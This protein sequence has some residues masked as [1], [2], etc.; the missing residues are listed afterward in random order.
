MDSISKKE[1]D[2]VVISFSIFIVNIF[3]RV[4]FL[5]SC[6]FFLLIGLLTVKMIYINNLYLFFVCI[7]NFL[8]ME[9]MFFSHSMAEYM[10]EGLIAPEMDIIGF[11]EGIPFFSGEELLFNI[12]IHVYFFI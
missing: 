11:F 3:S 9:V 10:I 4:E 2:Y 12:K 7:I 6:I 5:N 1:I 8:T